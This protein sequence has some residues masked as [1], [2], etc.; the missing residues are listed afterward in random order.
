MRGLTH[1]LDKGKSV[2]STA[3]TLAAAAAYI[4]IWKFGWG[5]A[6]LDAGLPGKLA[7]LSAAGV[8]T[9]LGGTLLEIAWMQGKDRECL[10]WAEADRIR[11]RRGIPRGRADVCGRQA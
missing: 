10:D 9:C 7:L 6:Y 1:V 11:Q 3:S 5:T 2:E 8:R 4:D